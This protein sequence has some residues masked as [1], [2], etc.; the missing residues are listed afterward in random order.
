MSANSLLDDLT[1]AAKGHYKEPE[2]TE[3]SKTDFALM[4]FR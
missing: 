3:V 4:I 1:L 2:G